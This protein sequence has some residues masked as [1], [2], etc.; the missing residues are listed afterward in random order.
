MA[1]LA[2]LQAENQSLQKGKKRE[3]E[4]KVDDLLV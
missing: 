2:A 3:A 1:V 4:G